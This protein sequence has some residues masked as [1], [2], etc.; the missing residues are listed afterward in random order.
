MVPN[1]RYLKKKDQLAL[2]T[3]ISYRGVLQRGCKDCQAEF[4]NLTQ[5]VLGLKW[6]HNTSYTFSSLHFTVI[7][8]REGCGH[9]I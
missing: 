6:P 4:H 5:S 2:I 8:S 9:D 7:H 1:E 3:T